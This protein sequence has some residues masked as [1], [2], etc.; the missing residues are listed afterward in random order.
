MNIY[1]EY[2][3]GY[4]VYA[5]IR[6]IDG[7][8]YYIGKGKNNRCLKKHSVSVPKDQSRIII[9][10][11]NLTDIGAC[12]IERRLIRWYG[13][14]DCGTGILRN[15]TD[16]GDGTSGRIISDQE[17]E[18]R[19]ARIVSPE[20]RKKMSRLAT[21]RTHSA[22]TRKK[23]STIAKG[24]KKNH[25]KEGFK[26]RRHSKETIKKIKEH[27]SNQKWYNNG[28]EEMMYDSPPNDSCWIPGRLKGSMNWWNDGINIRRSKTSPGPGWIRGR[29]NGTRGTRG[30]RYYNNGVIQ[31]PFMVDPGPGWTLGRIKLC[32]GQSEIVDPL[33]SLLSEPAP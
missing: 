17:M 29:L 20:T 8:P 25:F 16:G 32:S 11:Q 10:E 31:K 12:A 21:G 2:P 23:L 1:K 15:R 18:K 13:R 30:M 4:Y 33:S 26:G 14:K 5:Y 6:K 7:T 9:I 24:R 28:I 27:L 19:R 3:S 22:L